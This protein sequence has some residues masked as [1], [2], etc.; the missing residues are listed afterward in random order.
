VQRADFGTPKLLPQ[1]KGIK[2]NK[3][4]KIKKKN[5]TKK[6]KQKQTFFVSSSIFYRSPA[7]SPHFASAAWLPPPNALNHHPRFMY[8]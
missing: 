4:K 1:L 2:T 8:I 7:Q 5:K 6:T 3:Q